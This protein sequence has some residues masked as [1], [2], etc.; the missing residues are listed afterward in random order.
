MK[1]LKV[2]AFIILNLFLHNVP[3]HA[4]AASIKIVH[5]ADCNIY[6]KG[7]IVKGDFKKLFDL[8][9][10]EKGL[11][12]EFFNDEPQYWLCLDSQGGSFL[13]GL[14]IAEFVIKYAIGTR[15]ENNA[16]CFSSCA[17]IFMAGTSRG[18]DWDHPRR[19]LH[20]GGR[21]GFHAPHLT[22][23]D[24]NLFSSHE[25]EKIFELANLLM[26][27]FVRIYAHQSIFFDGPWIR[28]SLVGEMYYK[29][30]N[31][32]V[33]VDTVG[34]AGR[35][36]I[37]L[38]GHKELISTRSSVVQAC[39]NFQAWTSDQQSERIDAKNLNIYLPKN[40][41]DPKTGYYKVDTGGMMDRFCLVKPDDKKFNICSVDDFKG[42]H[43]GRCPETYALYPLL[44]GLPPDTR[45]KDLK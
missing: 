21:L 1:S 33:L 22:L 2:I 3:I 35:W 37:D 7:D 30:K 32:L 26:S 34:A 40:E 24:A 14:Q 39:L 12:R 43:I 11:I 20:V 5:K 13:E 41:P 36:Q 29:A 15:V 10:N 17:N 8:A 4:D 25:A 23:K 44:F 16:V 45:L 9:A 27:T 19:L 18:E 31:D 6:I 28:P 42:T 38:Y